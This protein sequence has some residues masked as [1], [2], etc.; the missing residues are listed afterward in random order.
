MSAA[1]RLKSP[2]NQKDARPMKADDS[3]FDQKSVVHPDTAGIDIGSETHYVS[4]PEDRAQPS[5]R[6]FG[7]FTPD[8]E[9][10]AV[11]LKECNIRH[12]V[13]EST[14]VYWIPTYQILTEAGFE[15][16]LVDA[17]HAKNVPGRKTDVWDCRWLRRLH[18]ESIRDCEA[19]SCLRWKWKR[20]GR[21]GAIARPWSLRLR[22]TRCGC[23]SRW[24]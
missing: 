6:T 8:L 16:R 5:V 19:V 13:M 9:A 11:W 17:R 24:S 1:S 22:N 3:L 4:V 2:N 15:V 10:L 18:P 21:I 14:G 7:C 12:V 23:K 20:C